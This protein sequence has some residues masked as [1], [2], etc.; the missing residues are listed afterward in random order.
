ML[1]THQELT[2][3]PEEVKPSDFLDL[4]KQSASGGW[5]YTGEETA[6][7]VDPSSDV[8][9]PADCFSHENGPGQSM[10]FVFVAVEHDRLYVSNVVSF[11]RDELSIDEY[12]DVLR[13][14]R[15]SVVEPAARKTPARVDL[16]EEEVALEEKLPSDV[17][18]R[19][20]AFSTAAN[21]M[22]TILYPADR[23]RWLSF[24]TAAHREQVE[25]DAHT[26]KRWLV[27]EQQWRPE[28]AA[29]LASEYDFSRRLLGRYSSEN[30][31]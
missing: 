26:L 24:L 7:L 31:A 23:D 22:T 10:V 8:W 3:I 14:F 30:G 27:E 9:Q 11:A 17:F 16:T 21:K 2:I 18:D 12:N 19:L 4:M 29:G 6:R 28:A 25:L 20:L 15:V 5:R 13:R 1:K